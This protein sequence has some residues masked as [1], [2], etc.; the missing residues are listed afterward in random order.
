LDRSC[1]KIWGLVVNLHASEPLAAAEEPRRVIIFVWDGFRPDSLNLQ[2]TP[3]L[4]AMLEAGVHFT[5]HHATY[6]TFTM[7]NAASFATG[8]FGGSTGYYGNMLWQPTATGKNS[9]KEDVN[10][11]QPIFSE[12]YAIL[13]DLANDL[14]GDLFMV[15]TL[16]SVAQKASLSTVTIGKTGAAFIQDYKCGG[17]AGKAAQA[18]G[19][20]RA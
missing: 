3:N 15:E 11:N 6:P 4:Y 5:D 7:M 12:D 18:R 8:S 16:F 19:A 14:K 17:N 1:D 20:R 13:I 2:D 10:F 9:L